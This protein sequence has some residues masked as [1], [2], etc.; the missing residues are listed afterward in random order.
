M[1]RILLG[2]V[3]VILGIRNLRKEISE[4]HKAKATRQER[5]TRLQQM[6]ISNPEEMVTTSVE[7]LGPVMMLVHVLTI[8]VGVIL[9]IHS[10]S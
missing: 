7:S 4:Y 3:F 9:V 10:Q 1:A 8:V 5:L 2:I 6:E